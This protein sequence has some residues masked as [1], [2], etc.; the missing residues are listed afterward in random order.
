[1][2]IYRRITQMP[3]EELKAV[4]DSTP[5]ISAAM[6]ELG[7]L[8]GDGR[9]KKYLTT[10]KRG[11]D[12]PYQRPF[13]TVDQ[14]QNAVDKSRTWSMLCLTLGKSLCTFNFRSLQ[15]FT[16][17]NNIDVSHF[18]SNPTGRKIPTYTIETALVE[19]SKLSRSSL[20]WFLSKHGLRKFSC[21]IC[22][23][24]DEWNNMSLKLEVDHINGVNNDNRVT[25]LRWVCPNCHSQTPTYR[26]GKAG[27]MVHGAGLE[28]ALNPL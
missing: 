17:E 3:L 15:K 1:M 12:A 4:I 25:N 18:E 22:N 9:I 26:K 11:T 8:S 2:S 19:D 21:E 10:I 13:Y 23:I 5:S 6:R 14:V 24:P 28:P 16:R 27:I 20:N 7:L